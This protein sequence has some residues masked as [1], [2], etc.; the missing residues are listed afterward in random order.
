MPTAYPDASGK[1][2]ET[3]NDVDLVGAHNADVENS[4]HLKAW[5]KFRRMTLEA[6][7]NEIGTTK[8]VIQQLESG[9]MGLSHKWLLKLAPVFRTTPGFLLDHDP[10]DID[11]AY[12]DAWSA[13]PPDDRPRA[14]QVL[15]AFRTGTDG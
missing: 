10:N 15:K 9:R 4:N 12:L 11:T 5:R 13:I 3:R 1:V 14:L 6:V 8:A 7:A 2:C